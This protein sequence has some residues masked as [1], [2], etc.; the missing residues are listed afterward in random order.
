M[1]DDET[2][3][4]VVLARKRYVGHMK[5][6]GQ[7]FRVGLLSVEVMH[8]CIQ[9]LFGDSDVPDEEKL[10]CV[11]TLLTTIGKQLEDA[12]G[13]QAKHANMMK[14]CI[15]ELESLGGNMKLS[16]RIRF[17][18][19]DLLELRLNNWTARREE[20]S[21]AKIIAEIHDDVAREEAAN[22]G[23]G[24]DSDGGMP[25]H[26]RS[27]RGERRKNNQP[28][29][30]RKNAEEC[31]ADASCSLF[32]VL[33]KEDLTIKRMLATWLPCTWASVPYGTHI[34]VF[35]SSPTSTQVW[36]EPV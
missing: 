20:E 3:E 19:R 28:R 10:Q 30:R 25:S 33:I 4:K 24:V 15:K 9:E 27:T 13:A 21:S 31:P 12:C 1:A 26:R 2:E 6:V 32:F 17:M 22:I 36:S 8:Y 16:L 11:C 18:I 29:N 34:S 35:A 23:K 7:L 14:K 5:F